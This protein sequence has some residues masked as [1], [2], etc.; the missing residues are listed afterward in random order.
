[1]RTS[2]ANTRPRRRL[3]RRSRRAL[4]I[5]ALLTAGLYV[6]GDI[7]TFCAAALPFFVALTCLTMDDAVPLNY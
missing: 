7:A 6:D 4:A 3:N 2:A 1:M 5:L